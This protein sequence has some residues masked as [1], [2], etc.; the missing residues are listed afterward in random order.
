MPK[1]GRNIAFH[2]EMAVP[3]KTIT[4]YGHK[5]QEPPIKQHGIYQ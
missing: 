3:G 1:S 5:E 2:K 4:K